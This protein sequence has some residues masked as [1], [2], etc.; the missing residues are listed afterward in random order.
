MPDANIYKR[1]FELSL[2]TV[3]LSLATSAL[4]LVV[5]VPLSSERRLVCHG[6]PA[7]V[8]FGGLRLCI[9]WAAFGLGNPCIGELYCR[10]SMH[11]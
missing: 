7:T 4:L 10:E 9:Y 1:R 8:F 3:V 2:V 5:V 6:L 11:W